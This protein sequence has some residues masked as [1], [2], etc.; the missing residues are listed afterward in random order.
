M[1]EYQ[2]IA[3]FQKGKD[4]RKDPVRVP[5]L[6]KRFLITG[7]EDLQV[8]KSQHEAPSLSSARE[9]Q[10]NHREVL[11]THIPQMSYRTQE[12]NKAIVPVLQTTYKKIHLSGKRITANLKGR[13][14]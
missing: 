11:T 5:G 12:G 1:R 4:L 8:K 7:E 14:G 10:K 2:V 6:R 13:R 3:P 9:M